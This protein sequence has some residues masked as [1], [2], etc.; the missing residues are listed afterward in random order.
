LWRRSEASGCVVFR[1]RTVVRWRQVLL[2]GLAVSEGEKV[3]GGG[4]SGVADLVG[5][6]ECRPPDVAGIYVDVA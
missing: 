3:G 1:C 2:V 5:A 6:V 4:A